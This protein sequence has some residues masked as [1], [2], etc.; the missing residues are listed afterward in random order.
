MSAAQLGEADRLR[1]YQSMVTIRQFETISA[2]LLRAGKLTGNLHLSLG[3]EAV[4]AGVCDVLTRTDPITTTHRGHGH[5]LAKGGDPERM[6]AEM[7][8]RAWGYGGGKAGSMHLADPGSGIL[9]AT[10]IVGGGL[11]MAVGA[12]WSAKLRGTE[13]VAVAF[14]GEGAVAEGTFHESLNIAAL[15]RLPVV[16]VCENNQY[17]E[18]LHV[19]MHLSAPP[20]RLAGS[21]GMPGVHVDGND[22]AAV[23]AAAVEAVERAR[24]GEGPSLL[25]CA[26]YRW[27]GHYEGDPERYR[28]REE[29]A[30]WKARDPIALL[31]RSVPAA[32]AQAIDRDIERSLELAAEAALAGPA[33]SPAGIFVDVFAG[34]PGGARR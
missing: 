16:F 5:C 7:A 21:Y 6:F 27:S 9:G 12:A 32:A 3:Q 19:S 15:W 18:L 11:P 4:A 29:V 8:G 1:L 17:A 23:R 22:V 10:A 14:F 28:S 24:R 26:T 30:A 31:R 25:E 2:R 33:A 13:D 20:H 34:S